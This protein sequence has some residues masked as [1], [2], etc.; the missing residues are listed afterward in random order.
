MDEIKLYTQ[1]SYAKLKGVSQ[2]YIAKL[3]K[4]RKLLE[5]HNVEERKFYIIDCQTNDD[6]FY[7]KNIQ[8]TYVLY[9]PKT[10]LFKIGK[11]MS[12]EKRCKDIN[13]IES[14]EMLLLMVCEQ[15]IESKLHRYYKEK[16]IEREM[17]NLNSVDITELLNKFKFKIV[18]KY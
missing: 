2:P 16:N 14:K 1:T 5:W 9:D 10:E 8:K 12:P 7:K 18:L 6:L 17:F 4:K 11:S 15:N 13:K 3:V